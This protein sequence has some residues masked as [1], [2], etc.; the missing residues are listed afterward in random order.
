M[1]VE[2]VAGIDEQG[3]RAWD[4]HDVEGFVAL[5]DD[6]AEWVDLAL[7]EPMRGSPAT[8]ISTEAGD[9]YGMAREAR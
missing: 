2:D 5:F 4:Q 6:S 7:P 1:S 8:R 9:R 3:I